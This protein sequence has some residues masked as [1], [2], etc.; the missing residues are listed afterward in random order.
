MKINFK[1]NMS[2]LFKSSYNNKVLM[3]RRKNSLVI[4]LIILALAIFMM[5]VPNFLFSINTKSDDIIKN[6]PEISK[7][8]EHLFTSSLDCSVK[9]EKL[10]CNENAEQ[11]NVVVGDDIK[12]TVIANAKSISIDTTVAYENKKDTDNIIILLNKYIKIRYVERDYVNEKVKVYEIIGDYSKF[13]GLNFKSLS[14]K[15][16]NKPE[17]L[18]REINSFVHNTYLSTLD[19][20]LLVI[21]SSS[22]IMLLLF[23]F[24]TSIIL[25]APSLFRRKKGFK[26][27]ECLKISLTSSL[28]ALF[29]GIVVYFLLGISFP[30]TYG[31]IYVIR[32]IYIYFKYII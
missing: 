6:F 4:P 9:E 22:A 1:E 5:A 17:L 24:V 30:L 11:I 19:T 3:D 8:L 21:L 28:P 23:V 32:I 27:S 10:V 26:F 14:D 16:S 18:S 29:F 7:P 25:K 2:S 12:Y 13:E 31:L 20:Q 15:I